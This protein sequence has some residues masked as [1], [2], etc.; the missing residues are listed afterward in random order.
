MGRAMREK[1]VRLPEKLLQIRLG[2][3][4]SQTGMLERLGMSK[5]SY[6]HYISDFENGG[7]EPSLPVLLKYA[8]VANVWVDVLI[9]D[10]LDL[11][12]QLP[13]SKKSGGIKR[14]ATPS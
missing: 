14:Q 13:C 3:E 11:P 2:L 8:Q 6:R 9:D 12:E 10:A 4:L 5:T 1:P 7:R